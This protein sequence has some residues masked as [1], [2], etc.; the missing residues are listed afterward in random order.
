MNSEKLYNIQNI[1]ELASGD[2]A[3][4]KRLINIF[5]TET[6]ETINSI[7]TAHRNGDQ[8]TVRK[9]AHR[10]KPSIKNLG[11]TAI[12]N[13]LIDVEQGNYPDQTEAKLNKISAVLVDVIIGLN[14]DLEA[15]D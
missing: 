15:M 9:L 12:I 4:V 7:Y 3:F 14:K 11:I 6:P 5:I 1:F 2:K 10:I 13:D 8:E